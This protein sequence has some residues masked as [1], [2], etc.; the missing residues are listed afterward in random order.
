MNDSTPSPQSGT[1]NLNV[2]NDEA[3]KKLIADGYRLLDK[4]KRERERKI[5]EQIKQLAHNEGLKVSFRETVR[6]RKNTES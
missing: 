4:R 3:I 1:V 5:K 6:R 2:L